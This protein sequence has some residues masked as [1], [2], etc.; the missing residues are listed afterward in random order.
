MRPLIGRAT[1][2]PTPSLSGT[3]Q[4]QHQQPPML[5]V[6]SNTSYVVCVSVFS[7]L[8]DPRDLTSPTSRRG[9]LYIYVI[10]KL[11][12]LQLRAALLFGPTKRAS[13]VHTTC[14]HVCS[15]L[16]YVCDRCTPGMVARKSGGEAAGQMGMQASSLTP[17]GG[18]T[19][20]STPRDG[21]Q[22]SAGEDAGSSELSLSLIHI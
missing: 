5:R 21:H 6:Y 17:A 22:K 12:C 19:S 15:T 7:I 20:S 8:R 18:S 13:L 2:C 11:F 14:A 10:A 4:Q 16:C 1:F 3:Q 9:T